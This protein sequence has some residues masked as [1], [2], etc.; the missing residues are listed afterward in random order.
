LDSRISGVKRKKSGEGKL[1]QSKERSFIP[2]AH[3][4]AKES[5]SL[6]NQADQSE[7]KH[8]LVM[9]RSSAKREVSQLEGGVPTD[10]EKC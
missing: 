9:A 2:L 1:P 8:E 7:W 6:R 10:G 3:R 4:G 5:L